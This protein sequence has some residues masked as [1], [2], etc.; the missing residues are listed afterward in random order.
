MDDSTIFTTASLVEKPLRD[1]GHS[2]TLRHLVVARWVL[3]DLLCPLGH[4]HSARRGLGGEQPTR[5]CA[6]KNSTRAAD[7]AIGGFVIPV[8]VGVLATFHGT[9]SFS[10]SLKLERPAGASLIFSPSLKLESPMARA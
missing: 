3:R 6:G 10:F 7:G 9:L 2:H 1:L 5:P 8:H 4:A